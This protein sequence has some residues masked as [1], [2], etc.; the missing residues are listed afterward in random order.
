MGKETKIGDNA[1]VQPPATMEQLV[2]GCSSFFKRLS[3]P[4]PKAPQSRYS[5]VDCLGTALSMF[6]LKYPSL[7]RY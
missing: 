7:Y 5:L 3:K 4:Y 2:R 1:V 6:V